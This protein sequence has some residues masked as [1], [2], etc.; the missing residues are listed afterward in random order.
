[1][2]HSSITGTIY[3]SVSLGAGNYGSRLTVTATGAVLPSQPGA[4]AV[5][6]DVQGGV[7]I[8]R[9]WIAGG[10]AY[11]GFPGPAGNGVDFA[12]S[13][14]IDNF[15]T[16]D[17][18]LVRYDAQ[19][20][21]I[22]IDLAAGGAISNHGT[23]NGGG[24]YRG[25]LGIGG[26][27]G[28]GV[29]LAGPATLANSGVIYGGYGADALPGNGGNGG[30]G[31]VCG[32]GASVTNAGTIAGGRG[33]FT[34]GAY[35]HYV[36][37]SGGAGVDM[38]GGR[39]VNHG[40]I[41]G[42]TSGTGDGYYITPGKAGDGVDL[43]GAGVLIN[44][45][46]I[47]GGI[48]HAA[49]LKYGHSGNGVSLQAGARL[50]N[51]GNIAGGGQYYYGGIG[52]TAAGASIRNTGSI[53]GGAAYGGPFT[54][55]AVAGAGAALSAGAQ[56]NNAGTITG[57]AGLPNILSAGNG[58]PGG[59]GVTLANA[60]LVNT[61][62]ISGGAGGP[63]GSANYV[64]GAGGVG[65]VI[66]GGV[67][68]NAGTIAGG[69]GGGGGAAGNAVQFGS[70]AATLVVNPGAAFSGNVVANTGVADM[71]VLAGHG[72]G[73]L[74]GIGTQFTG[75]SEITVSSGASWTLT[76]SNMVGN[77]TSLALNGWLSVTG[78]L[79]DAGQPVI[80]A[81]GHLL[82]SGG[83]TVQIGGA[84]LAG[85]ELNAGAGAT[86]VVGTS[87]AG[88]QAGCITIDAGSA[89]AGYGTLNAAQSPGVVDNG[90][91]AAAGGTLSLGAGVSG[92]G[93]I[94]LQPDSALAVNFGVSVADLGFTSGVNEKL[95]ILATGSVSST[96]SGFGT[97]DVIDVKREVHSLTF[98]AGTL[99]LYNGQTVVETLQFA[100][101]YTTAN[102]NLTSDGH[103]GADITY[104]AAGGADFL[105]PDLAAPLH[106]NV[107]R[108]AEFVTW[109]DAP[110][111]D[112]EHVWPSFGHLLF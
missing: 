15:G 106:P 61:G 64:G 43:G 77:A 21:G 48:C 82:A 13:G 32:T 19:N 26:N 50:T 85:G 78:S 95:L 102:F 47:T 9:G 7:L 4:T 40:S 97:G 83:G 104:V 92:T 59:A 81:H 12:A 17:G 105:P 1:M 63:A 96:I 68:T 28:A 101:T 56:L 25:M 107:D 62:T 23:I 57:G 73:T 24:A 5:Y 46:V 55:N 72:P 18:G 75:F 10:Y 91:F 35:G 36:A 14:R 60:G 112:G 38:S 100:G 58:V 65:V 52:V 3:S 49:G 44:D 74:G 66:S 30:A 2:H 11:Y 70:V 89:V 6:S 42:G 93:I 45:G 90:R 16:I 86:L 80:G 76:D 8:N 94:T 79:I 103:G 31:L 39:L 109:Q 99:T 27:G 54:P 37:G 51:A 34:Y 71:L 67:V 69:A 22:G 84:T 29:V 110:R 53:T 33:G 98:A 88:A 108:G 111:F 20:A 41:R 87:A